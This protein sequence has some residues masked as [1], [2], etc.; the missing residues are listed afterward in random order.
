[1][2]VKNALTWAV[3][4][5]VVA[6]LPAFAG[7]L[8]KPSKAEV[9]DEVSRFTGL[10]A[11]AVGLVHEE[12]AALFENVN[13]AVFA[14]KA[15]N[16]IADA[17]DQEL[18]TELVMQGVEDG[19]D[20]LKEKFL[21]AAM[22]GF[23]AMA[24]V[25]KASLEIIRDY[26]VVP[27]FDESIYQ[28]YKTSR[29]GDSKMDVSP[30]ARETAFAAGVMNSASGY[31]LVKGKIFDDMIKARGLNKDVMGEPMVKKLERQI[32]DF[33][34]NRL[35]TRYRLELLKAQKD[36]LKTET[37]KIVAKDIEAIRAAAAKPRGGQVPDVFF[38]SDGYLPKWFKRL[39][40]P[41]RPDDFK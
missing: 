41:Y 24:G 17:K 12:H 15:V 25:Y 1:M 31:Y 38:F 32:D 16:M 26:I 39:A 27:K 19:L 34:I 14:A 4:L 21:P 36:N 11:D 6:V 23:L 33:W 8:E 10:A 28:A 22:N 7:D 20:K 40:D 5:S 35:E 2:K 18:A 29:A 9:I 3:L 13:G 37:W 30:E